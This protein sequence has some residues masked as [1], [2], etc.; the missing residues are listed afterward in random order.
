MPFDVPPD[1][2]RAGVAAL[3]KTKCR[4]RSRERGGNSNTAME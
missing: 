4:L 3:E 2:L 1:E